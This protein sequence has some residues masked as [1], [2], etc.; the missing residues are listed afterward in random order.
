[1]KLSYSP[2]VH[3]QTK[4]ELITESLGED[5]VFYANSSRGTHFLRRVISFRSPNFVTVA[6]LFLVSIMQA[7]YQDKGHQS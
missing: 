3:Q 4:G 2:A 7:W 5:A 6:K 1:M